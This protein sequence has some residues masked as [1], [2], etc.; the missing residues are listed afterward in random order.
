M[1][2]DNAKIKKLVDSG[3]VIKEKEISRRT[4][5]F[6][7]FLADN[8]SIQKLIIDFTEE[9]FGKPT[10]IISDYCD[11]IEEYIDNKSKRYGEL[12][13]INFEKVKSGFSIPNKNSREFKNFVSDLIDAMSACVEHNSELNK[14]AAREK[15]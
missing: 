5:S 3:F 13:I 10:P 12:Y 14:K 11:Q 2:I 1:A 15:S 6:I 7:D 4:L 9:K 8:E